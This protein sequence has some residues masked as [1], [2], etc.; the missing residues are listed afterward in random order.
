MNISHGFT[1]GLFAL[2]VC[3]LLERDGTL[4][5]NQ[6]M[7]IPSSHMFDPTGPPRFV[8]CTQLRG[9]IAYTSYELHALRHR[10]CSATARGQILSALSSA[11]LLRYRGRRAGT[12]IQRAIQPIIN[13]RRVAPRRDR[14][15]SAYPA[16]PPRC[17]ITVPLTVPTPT[18]PAAATLPP[19]AQPSAPA[20]GK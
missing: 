17:L 15:S 12:R 2:L 3:G 11:G 10:P 1:L 14:F 13:N 5:V 8:P 19:L 6:S 7:A 9:S 20:L 4:D 18:R 16:P